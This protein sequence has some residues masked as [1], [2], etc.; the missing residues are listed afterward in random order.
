MIWRFCAVCG[1]ERHMRQFALRYG[2]ASLAAGRRRCVREFAPR[3]SFALLA[4]GRGASR[5]ATC[6]AVRRA[7]ICAAVREFAA[8]YG[9][10]PRA[11]GAGFASCF[12][13]FSK[14]WKN[15]AGKTCYKWKYMVIS[16]RGHGKHAQRALRAVARP[17][18]RIWRQSEWNRSNF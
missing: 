17:Q 15:I 1:A 12:A 2:I 5:T 8:P 10:V 4:A 11:T 9:F 3:R 6:S 14:F 7:G 18:N 13:K 16:G